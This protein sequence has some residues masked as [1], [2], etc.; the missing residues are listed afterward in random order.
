[1]TQGNTART[2]YQTKYAAIF[3]TSNPKPDFQPIQGLP[4]IHGGLTAVGMS[5]VNSVLEVASL[6]A[7]ADT[8]F[9]AGG[10][11]GSFSTNPR[12]ASPQPLDFA[13]A[14]NE[15]TDGEVRGLLLLAFCPDLSALEVEASVLLLSPISEMWSP[16]ASY[17]D[18][19]A[20]MYQTFSALTEKT[21]ALRSTRLRDEFR[22][23]E[24]LANVGVPM[25][26]SRDFTS[27][28]APDVGSP[29]SEEQPSA[30][31]MM[32]TA[33]AVAVA[34]DEDGSVEFTDTVTGEALPVEDPPRLPAEADSAK[35]VID[36]TAGDVI[37]AAV[38]VKS[39][40][41][42][43]TA[44]PSAVVDDTASSSA[45]VVAVLKPGMSEVPEGLVQAVADAHPAIDMAMVISAGV[46]SDVK[47]ALDALALMAQPVIL[48]G[49][50][51][52]DMLWQH[53]TVLKPARSE[54]GVLVSKRALS[55]E[56]A[57]D[58]AKAALRGMLDRMIG[59]KISERAAAIVN[60]SDYADT[61]DMFDASTDV[62]ST[63]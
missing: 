37:E 62:A 56:M 7:S 49:L 17:A 48:Q 4:R 12:N 53:N 29:A 38:E 28:Q 26:M 31:E 15:A 51:T 13:A 52:L 6:V 20:L 34:V 36:N 42:A 61:V 16:S 5:I 14:L 55:H 22:A 23:T 40:D 3:L 24:V 10:R 50:Q 43:D 60:A 57:T 21:C 2:A 35:G 41:T 18:R 58:E 63:A 46:R 44:S 11:M 32:P 47:V 54:G 1:M 19:L 27:A 39:A 25:P 33:S 30:P 45:V 8:F 9:E 59:D